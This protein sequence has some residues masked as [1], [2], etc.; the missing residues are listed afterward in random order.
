VALCAARSCADEIEDA[1][2]KLIDPEI[3]T[4]AGAMALLRYVA[5][6]E[7]EEDKP[8]SELIDPDASPPRSRALAPLR[9]G[10]FLCEHR[11]APTPSGLGPEPS[12][13]AF[14]L[15]RMRIEPVRRGLTLAV[16]VRHNGLVW[17]GLRPAE[18]GVHAGPFAETFRQ[19][20]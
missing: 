5:E 19:C 3:T 7:R 1:E 18:P 10:L 2:N 13:R 9:A 6:M 8:W 4:I 16:L 11:K 17:R 15:P 12:L 14:P 20:F